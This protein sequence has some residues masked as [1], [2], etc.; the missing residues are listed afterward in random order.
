MF[1]R[2]AGQFP[3][4]FTI[5]IAD[6]E[7]PQGNTSILC[8]VCFYIY[9]KVIHRSESRVFPTAMALHPVRPHSSG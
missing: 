7:A 2:Y 9:I 6:G 5:R 8:M 1:Y 4:M 3:S